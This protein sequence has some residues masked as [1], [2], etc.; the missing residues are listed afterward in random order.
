MKTAKCTHLAMGEHLGR[1]KAD[2]ILVF[3][4]LP[5]WQKEKRIEPSKE[6]I[7]KYHMLYI[8][9]KNDTNKIVHQTSDKFQ[10]MKE[11]GTLLRAGADVRAEVRYS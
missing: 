3:G 4:S 9:I 2:T 6:E 10:S 5:N 8:I 7:M 11:L 1:Q